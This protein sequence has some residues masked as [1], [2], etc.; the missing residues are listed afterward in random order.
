MLGIRLEQKNC[1][2][3]TEREELQKSSKR[4]ERQTRKIEC[5][6][7]KDRNI[8]EK[9]F[10]KKEKNYIVGCRGLVQLRL[11]GSP[12]FLNYRGFRG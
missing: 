3:Q 1:L 9:D 5:L 10:K 11:R 4:N 7:E 12:C 6:E 2:K 8:I